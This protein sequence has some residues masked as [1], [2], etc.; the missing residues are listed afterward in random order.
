M[1]L[2]RVLIK[3]IVKRKRKKKMERLV[4]LR[5][6][7]CYTVYCDY[8]KFNETKAKESISMKRELLFMIRFHDLRKDKYKM[9]LKLRNQIYSKRYREMPPS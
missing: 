1:N 7:C 2:M 9:T 6:I 4:F 5:L 3:N 8:R